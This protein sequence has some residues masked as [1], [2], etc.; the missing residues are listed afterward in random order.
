M[1]DQTTTVDTSLAAQ[2]RLC[3]HCGCCAVGQNIEGFTGKYGWH[4]DWCPI[5]NSY[6]SKDREQVPH[7]LTAC[8]TCVD[9]ADRVLALFPQS[10]PPKILPNRPNL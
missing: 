7:D 8:Q 2:H 1:S 6:P 10:T 9:H 5:G 4:E 3:P